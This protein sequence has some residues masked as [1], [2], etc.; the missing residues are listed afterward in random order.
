MEEEQDKPSIGAF[1]LSLLIYANDVALFG[2]SITNLQNRLHA[3]H[4]F[5]DATGLCV[6]VRKTKVM[7]VQTP[8]TKNWPILM[9]NGQSLEV[10][11]CFKYLG[12]NVPSNHMW[13]TCT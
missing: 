6:N 1:T 2:H 7:M 4:A 3:I 13:G 9:Y 11:D 5:C 8:K 12:I 10:V